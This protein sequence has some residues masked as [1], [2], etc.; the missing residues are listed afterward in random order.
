MTTTTPSTQRPPTNGAAL[1][2]AAA[3]PALRA[4]FS[5]RSRRF[6]LGAELTGP[7]AF[8]SEAD[9]VPLSE[10]EEAILVAA[11]TGITGVARDDW[12]FTDADG[13]RTGADKLGSFT[14][15]SY[16][17]PLATHGTELF[18]TNDD[19]VFFLPQRDVAP[20][21]YIQLSRQDQRHALYR[22]SV[23][24]QEGR[25][26]IP[27]RTP[28]LFGI[29][30]W[31]ANAPG[32][33]LFIPVSDVTRQCITAML[34]YFDEPHRYYIHDPRLGGD[35]LAPLVRQGWFDGGHGVDLWDFERWQ[36]VDINGVE[37]G[38][39][40]QNLMIATQ[41]LGL[42]GHPFSGGK[43]RVTMG[44]EELWHAI[45]G[46]GS[47]GGL[48]FRFSR[49]PDGAPV[50]GGE[51]VPVGL[52]GLFEGAL[53]PFHASMSEAV[54]AVL[55][56][57]WGPEGRFTTAGGRRL[58]WRDASPLAG[59]PRPAPEAVEATKLLCTYIW[60]TYGRF[61]ATIDPFLMTVWFQS[62]HLDIDFYDTHYPHAAVPQ[63]IRNHMRDWHEGGTDEHHR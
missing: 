26:D 17:S 42:G 21:R 19:G 3:Y 35:P 44:G 56:L 4:I 1:R 6:A 12:P 30:H 40:I 2:R 38:L 60:D 61:P 51:L 53:P 8:H 20:E 55:D 39:V 13:G 7:L 43:G 41:A 11:A 29:N 25:L 31:I 57:R 62:Q 27:T 24:L 33:T 59:I 10:A 49:V 32:T 52:P 22:R 16:P 48:G 54:D 15:R 50:G 37:Q 45:G 5:R 28:N 9:P 58:P 47:A 46:E 14:G 63:H 36:M 18:W 23:T 34:L